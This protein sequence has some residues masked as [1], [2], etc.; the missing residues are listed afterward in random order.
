VKNQDRKGPVLTPDGY[1]I[2]TG[3]NEDDVVDAGKERNENK[4]SETSVEANPTSRTTIDKDAEKKTTVPEESS[5]PDGYVLVDGVDGVDEIIK[6]AEK[7]LEE[8]AR[9]E[10]EKEKEEKKLETEKD[11]KGQAEEIEN[12]DPS[13]ETMEIQSPKVKTPVDIPSRLIA[14][15]EDESKEKPEKN[16]KSDRNSDGYDNVDVPL[17]KESEKKTNGNIVNPAAENKPPKTPVRPKSLETKQELL[18]NSTKGRRG[19]KNVPPQLVLPPD[20]PSPERPYVNSPPK[21]ADYVNVPGS[22]TRGMNNA[23]R[24]RTKTTTNKSGSKKL[25]LYD[26]YDGNDDSIYHSVESLMP[27]NP[28]Y[29]NLRAESNRSHSFDNI[30][31]HSYTNL[32]GHSFDGQAY[33]N[34]SPPGTQ[35]YVNVNAPKRRF[36]KNQNSHQ[37][38][39]IQV[40]G[41]DGM[42]GQYGPP[43]FSIPMEQNNAAAKN[44]SEYTWIDES[45]TR[46]LKET[47]RMHS[48]LRKENLPKV[49]KKY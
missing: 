10:E 13:Y 44:S 7:R 22:R 33:Q 49:T 48:D 24:S 39:Y 32:P 6:E 30:P 1:E 35:A 27:G 18:I 14:S 34:V 21:T 38:N 3:D 23:I 17:T 31:G 46:L 40:E 4:T 45:R 28:A 15:S 42:G 37:L 11:N 47:A 29:Q 16:D 26:I 41:T 9:K 12:M 19:I 5:D 25:N 8:K 20:T 2:M 43:S 36:Q